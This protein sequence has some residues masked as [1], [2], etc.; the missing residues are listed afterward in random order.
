MCLCRHKPQADIHQRMGSL[1]IHV[2]DNLEHR[3]VHTATHFG[4][5]GQR[6][7]IKVKFWLEPT[8]IQI[9]Q[10]GRVHTIRTRNL[11][12]FFVLREQTYR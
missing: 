10:I 4:V 6:R 12:H 2:L 3:M 5:I 9:P 8:P 1:R 7:L 11:L